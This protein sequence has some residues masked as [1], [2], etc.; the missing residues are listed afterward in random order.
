MNHF[1]H[2]TALVESGSI[3]E[4]TTVW[5]Y[6]HILP[7]AKIGRHC[8]ICDHTFIEN[9]VLLGDRVTVKCGVQLWDGITIEDD[10]FVGPNA[11]FTNDPF[12]RSKQR[13]G[14]FV[15]TILRQGCSIGANATILPGIEIGRHAMVGAGAV[16]THDVPPYAIVTGNPA[17]I[18]GYSTTGPQDSEPAATAA[19]G[20]PLSVVPGVTV[21]KMPRVEDLRGTLSFGESA[22][23]VPFEVRRYFLVFDVNNKEI[24]GQHAHRESH[25]FLICVHGSC[26][27]LVDNGTARQEFVLD[28]PDLGLHVA[29]MTWVVHYH[30]SPDAVL[31]VLA[32][33]YYDAGDYIRDYNEFTA[34]RGGA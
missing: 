6:S 23:H 17:R 1:A 9:E 33:D 25:Q 3:G 29:P 8:N 22:R 28:R 30:Y 21:H 14:E 31:M 19:G 13:P 34:G 10:V 26:H 24:R 2:A 5:A 7:G 16:V 20:L 32:S 4:G 27:I 18:S 12:P 11:T 15:R